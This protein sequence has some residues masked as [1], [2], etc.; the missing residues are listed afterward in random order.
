M[1]TKQK[2]KQSISERKRR[3]FSEEFKKQKVKEIQQKVTTIA[4][5]SRAYQV[6]YNNVCLWI[7]KYSPSYKKGVRLIVEMESDTKK[8]INQDIKIAELEQVVGQK[9]LMIDFLL[10]MIDLAEKDHGI[11]IKKNI[12]QKPPSTSGI[13]G[14]KSRKA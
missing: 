5:V 3:I 1:A 8:I 6:R 11:D 12:G 14:K 10:K 13:T 2:F 9:Q 4:E 7:Q